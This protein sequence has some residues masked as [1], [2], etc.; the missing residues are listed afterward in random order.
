MKI[1]GLRTENVKRVKL[2]EITPDGNVIKITGKN[3][4]GKTSILDSICLAL[5]GGAAQKLTQTIAPI[6]EGAE[7][8]EIKVD[9][10]EY[11]VTRT[12]TA[13]DKSYLKVETPDGSE[14]KS[15]QALL[16]KFIGGL[17]FDPL[18]FMNMS[19]DDQVKTLLQTIGVDPSTFDQKRKTLYDER[20]LVN[21][22][23][24]ELQALLKN[25][26]KPAA[27]LPD[28]EES[29]SE[30]M[31][32]FQEAQQIQLANEQE[33]QRLTLLRT[34]G[35]ANLEE[36][37]NLQAEIDR[38]QVA[39][40]EKKAAYESLKAQGFKQKE[41]VESLVDPDIS[42]IQQRMFSTEATN[43]KI[44]AR[45]EYL[46]FDMELTR[47]AAEAEALTVK[48]E[49]VDAEKEAAIQAADLPIP[50]LS[51]TD[52][53]V[54]Y[55]GIPL[56][57]SSHADKLAVSMAMG[58]KMNPQLRVILIRDGEKF[59]NDTW[60]VIEQLALANDYQVWCECVANEE[61]VGIY[62][63]DGMVKEVA[64]AVN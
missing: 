60:Q 27:D 9:L 63:E 14:L 20:T 64:E 62:I 34:A 32:Q 12:W 18:K 33:R 41:L 6:H 2:V 45:N 39:L 10:G 48:I 55:N 16:D 15:P 31:R 61:G 42:S 17:T 36:Q 8:G 1:V 4:Q 52:S 19:S 43:E 53:G 25:M 51:F 24:K 54:T 13:N 44:R 37:R 7:R 35:A 26:P 30:L 22:Q 38:L 5:G 49:A 58:M 56:S 50:G 40:T 59:D 21:R 46:K 47:K 3:R 11:V 23:V 29:A 57:Q 28:K